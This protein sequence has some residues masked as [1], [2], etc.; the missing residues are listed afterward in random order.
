[1]SRL[2][3]RLGW[4]GGGVA[5]LLTRESG[6]D[7]VA[8]FPGQADRFAGLGRRGVGAI[9]GVSL[10]HAVWRRNPGRYYFPVSPVFFGQSGR[11]GVRVRGSIT[12]RARKMMPRIATRLLLRP[13]S[14]VPCSV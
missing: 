14:F 4:P 6:P 9:S 7:G 8:D 13:V 5:F 11:P 3:S 12:L 1:M 10:P 2:F